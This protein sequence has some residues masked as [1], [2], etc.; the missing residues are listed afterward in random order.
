MTT[1]KGDQFFQEIHENFNELL[2]I[3]KS[4][5]VDLNRAIEQ[6]ELAR[7]DTL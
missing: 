1:P 3:V 7:N 5:Q 2:F 6:I 4:M